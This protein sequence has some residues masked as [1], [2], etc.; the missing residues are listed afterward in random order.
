MK[1]TLFLFLILILL[2]FCNLCYTY[3]FLPG[4][5]KNYSNF[6]F[7]YSVAVGFK[8]VYFG[9]TNGVTRYNISQK[10]WDTPLTGIEGLDNSEIFEIKVSFDDEKIWVRTESGYFE[11]TGVFNRWTPISQIPDETTNGVHVGL[12]FDYLPPPGYHYLNTGT[13]VDF[14]N[15][16]YP[17][18][19]IVDDGWGSQWIGT[20]GLGAFHAENSSRI[21]EPLTYGLLQEDVTAIYSDHGTLWIGGPDLGYTRP[22]FTAYD[23]AENSFKHID[24]DPGIL[25]FAGQVYAIAADEKKIFVGTDDGLLVIDKKRNELVDHLYQKSGLPDNRILSLLVHDNKLYVG[26]EYGLGIVDNNFGSSQIPFKTTLPTHAIL[27]LDQIDNHIWIGTDLGTFRLNLSTEKL[28]YLTS[29]EISGKREVRFIKHTEQKIWMVIDY[30]LKS[31]DRN[32]AEIETYPE[33]LQY[34]DLRSIAIS[35]TIVAAATGG[36]LLLLFD[37]K[38]DSHFLYTVG[39]G[40]ISNDIRDLVFDGDYIW[41]GTDKGLSR[42]WYKHPSLF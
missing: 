18:R 22:G 38:K 4:L 37:G 5:V 28:G 36:G 41:L 1:K 10:Q 29:S 8:Y 7:V 26:T 23:W 35:D 3:E 13:L 24:T 30:E 6:S 12:E 39:D 31:I 15:N 9:T 14:Y 33:I 32:S 11:Y 40:L 21:L 42:F 17:L 34:N 25:S 27:S 20:W 2:I 19:D 16:G